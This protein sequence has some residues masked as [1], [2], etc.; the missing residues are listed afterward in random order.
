VSLPFDNPTPFKVHRVELK[1]AL[2]ARDG[3]PAKVILKL[4]LEAPDGSK[5]YAELFNDEDPATFPKQGGTETFILEAPKQEGWS[6]NAKR[7]GRGGFGGPRKRDPAET[8]AIQ[9]QHSQ[10]MALRFA[11]LVWD[12]AASQQYKM[13]PEALLGDIKSFTDWFQEDIGS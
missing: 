12:D 9:R 7:P 2:P 5:G 8:K 1:K 3:K 6:A 11:A 4:G 10:E 13:N